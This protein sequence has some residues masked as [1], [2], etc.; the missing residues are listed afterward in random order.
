MAGIRCSIRRLTA[1]AVAGL[2]A[3]LL[4]LAGAESAGAISREV[5]PLKLDPRSGERRTPVGVSADGFAGCVKNVVD[6]YQVNG[7]LLE[8]PGTVVIS[9][10]TT[11][12]GEPVTVGSDGSISAS[13]TV[14]ETAA[15]G[16]YT[17]R[18]ECVQ[19][20]KL[21]SSATFEVT[22]VQP[23]IVPTTPELTVVPRI[24]GLLRGKALTA[25][26]TA[27]LRLGRVSGQGDVVRSQD[28]EAGKEVTPGSAVDITV[29]SAT[30]LVVVP[31]VIR[32]SPEA[33]AEILEDRGL[34]LGLVDGDGELIRDQFPEPG[35]EVPAGSAV[36]VTTESD[37]VAPVLVKVPKLVGR[38]VRVARTTLTAAGLVL[39]G[40][41][42]DDRTVA[43]QKPAAG[44]FVKPRSVVTVTLVPLPL[45]PVPD[46]VGGGADQA[47]TAL[48]A[49]GLVFG[50]GSDS[51][52]DI[53]SQQPAAGTLVPVGTPVAVTFDPS[54]SALPA[55]V[56][57]A[58]LLGVGA[59]VYRLARLQ[60]DQSFVRN[61][62][63]V[64]V[65]QSALRDPRITESN[66]SPALPV[67][68]LEPHADTGTHTLEEG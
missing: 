48:S 52:G 24:V 54:P 60:L 68:R 43:S 19:N 6:E 9:F 23:T 3:L 66:Q 44:T 27:G 22:E 17:V 32:R 62:V 53:V 30:R 21:V 13:F 35:T 46:L 41:P 34:V 40:K 5:G 45:V 67:V 11:P 42:A 12:M 57:A 37:N 25:L 65:R 56:V 15:P 18:A 51:D 31:R 59:A 28:P 50:G 36:S 20:S 33:A 14:P 26:K 16:P 29:S 49:V 8:E 2:L 4:A 7:L 10:G 58:V 63:K 47:R 61:K 1:V 39:G 38:K 64:A 55:I